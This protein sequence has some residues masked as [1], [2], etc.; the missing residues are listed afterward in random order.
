MNSSAQKV[1]PPLSKLEEMIFK[2]YKKIDKQQ[3]AF[4]DNTI[5]DDKKSKKNP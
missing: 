4:D 5:A 1:I 3:E 2:K